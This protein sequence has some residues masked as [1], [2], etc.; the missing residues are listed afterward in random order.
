MDRSNLQIAMSADVPEGVADARTG[1]LASRGNA[2]VHGLSATT[3]LDAII[4][5]D[6]L[7]QEDRLLTAE[8]QPQTRSE[9]TFVRE[10]ARHKKALE[11]AERA[12]AAI[13]R[14]AARSLPLLDC[15]SDDPLEH[16]DRLL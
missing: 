9:A 1:P 12:E 7:E 11:L 5:S 6:A 2:L 4:G 15:Q 8:F 10:F 3:L 16:E 13:L 14:S